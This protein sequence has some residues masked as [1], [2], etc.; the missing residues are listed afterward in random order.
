M[1]GSTDA[2]MLY[3]NMDTG[4]VI[5]SQPKESKPQT[6]EVNNDTTPNSVFYSQ[7][8][9]TKDGVINHREDSSAKG[10][11]DS[12]YSEQT[13]EENVLKKLGKNFKQ[14]FDACVEHKANIK[15]QSY[16]TSNKSSVDTA[17]ANFVKNVNDTIDAIQRSWL[18]SV[19]EAKDEIA[20]EQKLETNKDIKI[21]NEYNQSNGITGD[22]TVN[23]D[24]NGNI[25]SLS[26]RSKKS[27]KTFTYVKD[28]QSGQ[29][30]EMRDNKPV[31][32]KNG[33][34]KIYSL[35]SDGNLERD[36]SNIDE[37]TFQGKTYERL[38]NGELKLKNGNSGDTYYFD[39]KRMAKIV[40]HQ[41]NEVV[42]TAQQKPMKK[43]VP[44]IKIPDNVRIEVPKNNG[45]ASSVRNTFEGLG[46]KFLQREVNG[47]KQEIVIYKDSNGEKHRFIIKEDGSTENLIATSTKGKNKYITNSKAK[48]MLLERYGN[49]FGGYLV[50]QNAVPKFENGQLLGVTINGQFKTADE[51]SKKLSELAHRK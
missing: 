28:K 42:I 46:A 24:D 51:L 44:D 4:R 25:Q 18:D 36:N 48:T 12:K 22:V 8:D 45:N 9:D 23:K 39:G 49:E 13:V 50:K 14:F 15:S 19:N 31:I 41:I 32:D 29:Y 2:S 20:R 43:I 33:K 40:T 27:G 7:Y 34:Q 37:I 47:E 10:F 3:P 17:D 26:V 16:D 5:N 11:I 21:S 1:P 38:Y 35:T 30:I 6:G